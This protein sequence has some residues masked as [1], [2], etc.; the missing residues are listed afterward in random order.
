MSYYRHLFIYIFFRSL[1]QFSSVNSYKFSNLRLV[2]TCEKKNS[3][4]SFYIQEI[5]SSILP[6]WNMRQNLHKFSK[7][8]FQLWNI[9]G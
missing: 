7:A 1:I 8:W 9:S 2:P 6:E 5:S 3:K 4:I